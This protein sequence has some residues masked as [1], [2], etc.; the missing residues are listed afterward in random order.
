MKAFNTKKNHTNKQETFTFY[1]QLI[2]KYICLRGEFAA[3]PTD[4]IFGRSLS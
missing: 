1:I 2:L 4:K 3:A